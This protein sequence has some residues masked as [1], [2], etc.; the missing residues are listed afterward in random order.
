MRIV[1]ER[2]L[3]LLGVVVHVRLVK[4][5]LLTRLHLV[6]KHSRVLGRIVVHVE[7]LVLSMNLILNLWLALA[8]VVADGRCIWRLPW[9]IQEGSSSFCGQADD[10]AWY[11]VAV[12]AAKWLLQHRKV[13][14]LLALHLLHA[15]LVRFDVE[16]GLLQRLILI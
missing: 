16:L 14:V 2:V 9:Q 10:L 5:H 1:L 12:G 13:R 11:H 4:V 6:L 8:V 15:H 7:E 3:R